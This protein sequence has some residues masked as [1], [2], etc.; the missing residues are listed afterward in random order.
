MTTQAKV[1]V[2]AN[3]GVQG[4]IVMEKDETGFPS[5][6]A[7]GTL[8]LKDHA[9]YAY[10]SLSGYETWYPLT[11]ATSSHV[12]S[13]GMA[14]TQWTITH[15]LGTQ[16]LWW[17]VKDQTGQFV[18][19][20]NVVYT[21]DNEV[22]LNFAAAVQGTAILVAPSS[23]NLPSL[24]AALVSVGGGYVVIDSSGITIDGETVLT[25][26][27]SYTTSQVDDLLAD[28][29]DSSSVYTR[30]QVDQKFTD[31]I[32][33]AP[34]ALNTLG[35][36]ADALNDDASLAA[37]LTTAIGN[38][39]D[40]TDLDALETTVTGHIGSRGTAHGVATTT[41][42]GF[43]SSTDKSKLNSI[44]S[45]AQV[46]TV[47]SVNSQTGVVLLDT[48]DVGEGGSNLY[49][50]QGR[51]RQAISVSGSGSYDQ[52][53]GVIT[54]EGGVTSVNGQTGDVTIDAVAS[55]NDLTDTPTLGTAAATDA[56][57]YAT[58]A[59]GSLADSAVQPGDLAAVATSGSYGDLS[60]KPSIP[61][62]TSD[63]TNDS[64]FQNGT[65]V[66]SAISAAIAGKANTSSLAA[67]ALSGAYGDLSGRPSL[68][69]VATSGS[70][71]DLTSKPSIPSKVSDLTNDSGFLTG[72]TSSQVTTALG[73]TPADSAA[74][75]QANGYASLDGSGKVPSSQLPSYVDDVVEAANAAARPATGETGKIYVT[76]DNNKIFRWSGSA[77]VEIS[78]SPGS[79]DA[80]TEGSTNLYFTQARARAAI[81]AGTNIGYNSSTGVISLNLD[82]AMRESQVF[83]LSSGQTT[84]TVTGGYTAGL[85]DVYVNGGLLTPSDDYT[86]SNGTTVVLAE[87]G[88]S[89]GTDVAVVIVTRP[90]SIADALTASSQ[91][92][93]AKI[94]G[95]LGVAQGG[96]GLTTTPGSN[97]VLIGN[98]TGYDL[99]TL[100]AGTGISVDKAAGALTISSTASVDDATTT[101]AGKVYGATDSDS[102]ALGYSAAASGTD[103]VAVGAYATA[104]ATAA[105]AIGKG[106]E[107]V[108]AGAIVLNGT[109]GT[110]TSTASGWFVDPIRDETNGSPTK[111]LKFDTVTNE[112]FYGSLTSNALVDASFT[113]TSSTASN[114]A[115]TAFGAQASL[116]SGTNIKTVNSTSL[117]GSG[118]VSVQATLVSGT[119]I[120]TV[121]STSLLGS[122]NIAVQ[123]TLVSGTNIKSVNGTS[124]LGSGDLVVSGLP[125]QTGNSGKLLTTNA[126][127]ASWTAIKTINGN[128][129]L[130]SGDITISSGSTDWSTLV[131]DATALG[132]ARTALQLDSL[133]TQSLSSS[134]GTLTVADK[135]SLVSV[136]G[137]VTIPASIFSARHTLTI[138]N[139]SASTITLTQGSGLTMRLVGT[140][141]TGNRTLS[142]RGMATLVFISGTECVIAGGGVA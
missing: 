70:Y 49:F 55:Y 58:A 89:A 23:L 85:I 20:S 122:G 17:Q 138:Y 43:M 107:A 78:A 99:L 4:A 14:A 108:H 135:G 82:P 18:M 119:N 123:A 30:T 47:D 69:P 95:T 109:D 124:L 97:K 35:E 141:S 64:S 31:L 40:Q 94:T 41:E 83:T 137:G 127:D 28:K 51:A 7:V 25:S 29:A 32:G 15:N 56:T 86:A 79:T 76:L 24:E 19:P 57:D 65:Q 9:L 111:V 100:T 131:P 87:G 45:G 16:Q 5:S 67:V 115:L 133:Y 118:D 140:S 134:G 52:A 81:S 50:T 66:S 38:K 103:S 132:S 104:S 98:G 68:A 110:L 34:S 136:T 53:T 22:V 93:A 80:V 74:K 77:Y 116:V 128:S 120:K 2:L 102:V 139:N 142:Q 71:T 92:A 91:L 125:T 130:G 75:G 60:N 37:T 117:L 112:I 101:V 54:I 106:A 33:T 62:K 44:A 72:I 21:N 11:N 12:H 114:A 46:N 121:N 59:Q 13:Q 10:L 90:F 84:I 63:L 96:T 36:I 73:F 126:T 26:S 88:G 1:N 3:L 48:D 27:S 61:T 129:L 113:F 6:P 42:A 39:A 8:L 105:I